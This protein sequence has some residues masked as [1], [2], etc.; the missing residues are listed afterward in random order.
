MFTGN[1]LPPQTIGS[2]KADAINEFLQRMQS[3]SNDCFAYGDD[4]SDVPMLESVGHPIAVDGGRRLTEYAK[5][6]GWPII[7]PY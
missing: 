6:M 3:D 5:T 1:I 4:I 2:G 7:Q